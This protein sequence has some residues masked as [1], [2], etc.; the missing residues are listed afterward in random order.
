MSGEGRVKI[1]GLGFPNQAKSQGGTLGQEGGE[2]GVVGGGTV[3]GGAV[4]ACSAPVETGGQLKI[5]WSC[6]TSSI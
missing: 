1:F 2:A 4:V 3:T 6:S 5:S